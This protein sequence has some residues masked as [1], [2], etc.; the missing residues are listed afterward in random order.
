MSNVIYP[1]G[2]N[3]LNISLW[4]NG[5]F[6]SD[7][8]GNTIKN[9]VST[10]T[11]TNIN[12]TASQITH[13][14]DPLTGHRFYIIP[15]NTNGI[16]YQ[17]TPYNVS[18]LLNFTYFCVFSIPTLSPGTDFKLFSTSN[19]FN[20]DIPLKN[21]LAIGG[22]AIS[23]ETN[24][25]RTLTLTKVTGTT[26][27]STRSTETLYS[28]IVTT[29]L[30]D[31]ATNT[32]TG[33]Y[34]DIIIYIL[35]VDSTGNATEY[36]QN[37]TGVSRGTITVSGISNNVLLFRNCENFRMYETG[38]YTRDILDA[39][40]RR[41]QNF[42]MNKYHKP[43]TPTT[44]TA[45][46]NTNIITWKD[47]VFNRNL[48]T[49]AT[50][51]GGRI[52][53][54]YD[55]FLSPSSNIDLSRVAIDI[56]YR[57]TTTHSSNG[58]ST[59]Y[60]PTTRTYSLN[61][62]NSTVSKLST[63]PNGLYT[64]TVR[65]K[66]NIYTL[67]GIDLSLGI[68]VQGSISNI[69]D[70]NYA[71]S[72]SVSFDISF[73][74]LSAPSGTTYQLDISQGSLITTID[75]TGTITSGNVTRG[76]QLFKDVINGVISIDASAT[77]GVVVRGVLNGVTIF[78][79]TRQTVNTFYYVPEN[80]RILYEPNQFY[81]MNG[82]P[83]TAN[84]YTISFTWDYNLRPLPQFFTI[85]GQLNG[86]GQTATFSIQH[87]TASTQ[88]NLT[89]NK[90]RYIATSISGTTTKTYR[91]TNNLE[92]FP[93]TYRKIFPTQLLQDLSGTT[94][95][96][97][98]CPFKMYIYAHN[99]S[100]N[101]VNNL[102]N[103]RVPCVTYT[104][105]GF[106]ATLTTSPTNRDKRILIRSLENSL[107]PSYPQQ[108]QVNYASW[109]QFMTAASPRGVVILCFA[110]D[111]GFVGQS[112]VN[113]TQTTITING[114]G[115]T[116]NNTDY[117]NIM[118][119]YTLPSLTT[120]TFQGNQF[121]YVQIRTNSTSSGLNGAIQD[122]AG[123]Y[124]Y[125]K[126][127]S[128]ITYQYDGQSGPTYF[129]E[130]DY[131][132]V[133][134][135][136]TPNS[137]NFNTSSVKHDLSYSTTGESGYI[138]D[139]DDSSALVRFVKATNQQYTVNI[140]ATNGNNVANPYSP[141]SGTFRS[142]Y[143]YDTNAPVLTNVTSD[144]I[145]VNIVN[146]APSGIVNGGAAGIP[147]RHIYWR[148]ANAITVSGISASL[149]TTANTSYTITGLDANT[150]YEVFITHKN[151]SNAHNLSQPLKIIT[152]PAQITTRYEQVIVSQLNTD[153]KE[154]LQIAWQYITPT[155]YYQVDYIIN[156]ITT[157]T[158]RSFNNYIEIQSS[159]YCNNIR[160]RVN[161]LNNNDICGYVTNNASLTTTYGNYNDI[162]GPAKVGTFDSVTYTDNTITTT[163][164]DISSAVAKSCRIIC[165]NDQIPQVL[166][167]NI[168]INLNTSYTTTFSSLQTNVEYE[169]YICTYPLPNFGGLETRS[170]SI[171]A[172]PLPPTTDNF[173]NSVT[174]NNRS[175]TISNLIPGLEYQIYLAY[176]DADN[177]RITD[178]SQLYTVKPTGYSPSNIYSTTELVKNSEGI[179]Q[180]RT[181]LQSTEYYINNITAIQSSNAQLN[182]STNMYSFNI[183]VTFSYSDLIK[184]NQDK[185]DFNVQF[186]G[187]NN[188]QSQITSNDYFID[189]S[190]S[191]EVTGLNSSNTKTHIIT[192]SYPSFNARD[193][194]N[195]DIKEYIGK[196]SVK[197]THMKLI[198]SQSSTFT[199]NIAAIGYFN[200][201]SFYIK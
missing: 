97:S 155:P 161:T 72:S 153:I 181:Y 105:R 20:K 152:L 16:L 42:F 141:L 43:V 130:A 149:A 200:N 71:T 135:E 126:Q 192:L 52:P 30:S 111:N 124:T 121:I 51:N 117:S 53:R 64:I 139:I 108:I 80:V 147:S 184:N 46:S 45:D 92:F 176:L 127:P 170:Q 138:A 198:D 95:Y 35:R 26:R 88:L 128:N 74:T 120:N 186:N 10:T 162:S 89:N 180:T 143:N 25:E 100:T 106:S 185:I 123:I 23:W 65:P 27:L 99:Y 142:L 83:V 75:Y 166:I 2:S 131:T 13:N 132:A 18:R 62:T 39:S 109:Y 116:L 87:I 151:S 171:F 5:D 156:S 67:S 60:N 160:Y 144:S 33:F 175:H 178:Y 61:L 32:T 183:Q 54:Q 157:N 193:L 172:V 37:N 158:D 47:G 36:F 140:L 29:L 164:T 102:N 194:A 73:T 90:Y 41:L 56:P 103:N 6:E 125:S 86:F 44:L 129:F 169:M 190:A 69:Q 11:S 91:D 177:N 38:Y 165:R 112:T 3:Q 22:P 196:L 199:D 148:K 19:I 21:S 4:I 31:S 167:N 189:I 79:S 1:I 59:T 136:W 70:I 179:L 94:N 17:V 84:D 154:T 137:T 66:N 63:L 8:S 114:T 115:G 122:L 77:Y 40:A 24:A 28:N 76:T 145:I 82:V 101:Q 85:C 118:Q 55:V 104:F 197:A 173:N 187:R 163:I 9:K 191:S 119:T 96:N 174:S 12:S 110:R 78:R 134:I 182:T 34:K 159:Q 133:T 50:A 168:S 146:A 7:L 107:N 68:N 93:E 57:P 48:F 14:I 81:S 15:N 49:S 188:K 195:N 150:E 98:Y 58:S 201:T 113:S